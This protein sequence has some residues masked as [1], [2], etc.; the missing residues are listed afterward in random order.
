MIVVSLLRHLEQKWT[1]EAG[2]PVTSG[3]VFVSILLWGIPLA[4]RLVQSYFRDSGKPQNTPTLNKCAVS[5]GTQSLFQFQ[6][7]LTTTIHL[8][9]DEVQKSSEDVLTFPSLGLR[10]YNEKL[11]NSHYQIANRE[12]RLNS[13][14]IKSEISRARSWNS[15]LTSLGW[16][17]VVP[18][19]ENMF[20]TPLGRG[21]EAD[22]PHG[23]STRNRGKQPNKTP[24]MG[25]KQTHTM[26]HFIW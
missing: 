20:L 17:W 11:Q 9:I 14:I 5:L 21:E 23:R 8:Q 2:L 13:K 19:A 6:H 24:I 16:V 4:S 3:I 22:M 25:A 10:F 26:S 18:Q 12:S 15:I 7:Y 1:H